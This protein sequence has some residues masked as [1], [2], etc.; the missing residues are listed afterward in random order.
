M[1]RLLL[2]ALLLPAA[3]LLVSPDVSAQT[4]DQELTW[5]TYT[6]ERSARVRVFPSGDERRPH[7][8]VVDDQASNP[9][10]VT[11]EAV[12]VADL[13]GRE[14]GFDP[15]GA[16]F[17]FR[18]TPASFAADAPEGGKTL[19][20]RATF[21]RTSSGALASPSWRLISAD[22]LEDLTDRAMR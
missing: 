21:G 5:R 19:L 15:V 18:F 6:S 10:A 7:T 1:C 12:Y 16:T 22:E 9:A 11:D 3:S 14:F 20:V 17:V 2:V 8:V 4:H 13:V